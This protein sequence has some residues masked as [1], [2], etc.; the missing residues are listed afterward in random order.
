MPFHWIAL[1]KRSLSAMVQAEHALFFHGMH[2]AEPSAALKLAQ[3]GAEVDILSCTLPLAKLPPS[4]GVAALTQLS[5]L[6]L[7]YILMRQ[8]MQPVCFQSACSATQSAQ[9]RQKAKV[10]LIWCPT[11]VCVQP[12]ACCAWPQQKAGHVELPGMLNHANRKTC[13]MCNMHGMLVL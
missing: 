8:V 4:L 9:L 11:Q 10:A 1:P 7:H 12:D 5:F 6:V 3:S 2:S 13:I